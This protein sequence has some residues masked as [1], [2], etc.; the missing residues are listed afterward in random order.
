VKNV[1]VAILFFE[2]RNNRQLWKPQ[3]ILD[4]RDFFEDFKDT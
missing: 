4:R 3:R 2:R 1:G